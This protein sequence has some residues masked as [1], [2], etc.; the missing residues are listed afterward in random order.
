M[1]SLHAASRVAPV[2]VALATLATG[3]VPGA[4]ASAL[5][6]AAE[7][8]TATSPRAPAAETAAP[9]WQAFGE[10]V[11]DRLQAGLPDAPEA[12]RVELARAFVT[13]RVQNLRLL[14]ALQ[15]REAVRQA[16]ELRAAGSPTRESAQL[17]AAY[18]QRI[19]VSGQAAAAYQAERDGAI[20]RVL[21]LAGAA[22]EAA[23]AAKAALRDALEVREL[24]VFRHA[25]PQRLPAQVLLGRV[26]VAEA[27]RLVDAHARVPMLLSGWIVPAGQPAPLALPGD[28]LDV[29]DTL[30]QAGQEVSWS[31]RQLLDAARE[32]AA[33]ASR[34]KARELELQAARQRVDA[35]DADPLAVSE[36]WQQFLAEADEL[37][38][39]QGALALAWIG[40]QVQAPGVTGA[41]AHR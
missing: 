14:N 23:A 19:A 26:D 41:L 31:L 36:A 17:L 18:D 24:P 10:P 16:R 1:P 37:A 15:L 20:R 35:G 21:E 32:A 2:V 7:T 28:E 9:W 22:P 5:R 3:A 34:L 12:T 40:L 33:Q 27:T 39:A 11:L 6:S 25:V 29:G 8:V 13:L 4:R 30:R 38:R